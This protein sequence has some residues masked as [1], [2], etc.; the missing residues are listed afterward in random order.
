MDIYSNVI[1]HSSHN[2]SVINVGYRLTFTYQSVA[3]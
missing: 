2:R 3:T 1:R